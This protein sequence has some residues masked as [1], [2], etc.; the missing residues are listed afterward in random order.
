MVQFFILIRPIRYIFENSVRVGM[1]K[2]RLQERG[3]SLLT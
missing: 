1:A 2:L 3:G